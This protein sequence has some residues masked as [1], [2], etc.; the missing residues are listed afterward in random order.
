[1]KSTDSAVG[2]VG[3]AT[4]RWAAAAARHAIP[5]VLLTIPVTILLG[6]YAVRNLGLNTDTGAMISE[7]LPWR[8]AFLAFDEEFP[9][10]GDEIHVLLTGRTPD[11]ARRAA[12]WMS[13]RMRAEP[14]LFER[15]WTPGAGQFF[16][17]NAL[18]YMDLD[19]LRELADRMATIG[20]WVRR[21]ERDPG[22]GGLVVASDSA[23]MEARTAAD[24][25]LGPLF[26]LVSLNLY[27]QERG[28]GGEIS[29]D[30]VMWGRPASLVERRR[31]IIALPRQDYAAGLPAG[32]A[33]DRL[34]TLRDSLP[35]PVGSVTARI[36]GAAAIKHESIA[37]ATDGARGALVLSLLLVTAVLSL[38]LG[39]ARLIAAC[40]L[41]LAA[42]LTATAAFAAATVGQ[43]NLISI[44]FAVLYVGLG[45]DYCIH[46][47][48]GYRE[49][50][51]R[52]GNQDLALRTACGRIGGSVFLSAVTS[53]AAFYAFIPTRFTGVAE[54]GLI[55]GTGM[56][57]SLGATLTLLPALL[58]LAPLRSLAGAPA[59]GHGALA[60]EE[61]GRAESGA[62]RAVRN[63]SRGVLAAALSL[64][65]VAMLAIPSLR[66]EYRPIDLADPRTESV[67]TYH[68]L[69]REG[70]TASLTLS[71]VVPD[72][73][74]ARS[75]ASRL[76]AL[77]GIGETVTLDDLVPP[78]QF[79][80][81]ELVAD[82]ATALGPA[83]GLATAGS[84]PSSPH[85]TDPEFQEEVLEAVE[86]WMVNLAR[87][88]EPSNPEVSAAAGRLRVRL[89]SWHRELERWPTETRNAM[90]E[91]L[92]YR[93]VGS[94]PD[95][96]RI[97]RA[98]FQP[99]SFQREDLPAPV[100][101]WWI[102]TNG[103][104]RVEVRPDHPLDTR[105]SL[106]SFVE[107]VRRE[108]PGA[109]GV[110]VSDLESGRVATRALL[111]ALSLAIATTFLFLVAQFRSVRDTL[112]VEGPLVLAGLLTVGLA[113]LLRVPFNFANL[114]A[115]PLLLGIGVDN[116]IHM[117]HRARTSLPGEPDPERT[118][119]GRA[120]VVSCLT[121]LGSFG[122]LALSRHRGIQSMGQLL[123]I[124]MVCVLVSTLVVLPAWLERQS[125]SRGSVPG[126]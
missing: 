120:I 65:A 126:T 87:A 97:L 61:T 112:L 108:H 96:L 99:E 119:T 9:Q 60:D 12:E 82:I 125:A 77:D 66:F 39:S 18:L 93:L 111:L 89:A 81:V 105:A 114:I 73:A 104:E 56:L 84:G 37:A 74:T 124:G 63:H 54:L 98:A 117:V 4:E 6:A 86:Q 32:P 64:G 68:E 16:D 14:D 59:P 100:R 71:V 79:E 34:R 55:S 36:T 41:T 42:G 22:L 25:M 75:A 80:K 26:D 102:G 118:S 48:L 51:A 58:T 43:L 122:S 95:R 23:L 28:W 49:A 45:V 83:A 121:T 35:V 11:V 78:D 123:S 31:H 70:G 21:L 69:A 20:P 101:E 91:E 15:V 1:M 46:L 2:L 115:L 76:A 57:I 88:G 67:E 110:P 8:Q 5:V 17:R 30:E 27:R 10:F 50:L 47:C 3:R 38:G 19:E 106:R 94:L 109:T 62:L 85:P 107:H 90:L 53:A 116:G 33:M 92:H 113:V 24:P 52:L 44:A 29:W 7:E 40:L 13:S 72:A 103:R